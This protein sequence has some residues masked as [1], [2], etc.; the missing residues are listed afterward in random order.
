MQVGSLLP[1][2][3]NARKNRS[4]LRPALT[5]RRKLQKHV[6]VLRNTGI[7]MPAEIGA[8]APR[9]EVEQRAAVLRASGE[10]STSSAMVSASVSINSG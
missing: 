10:A 8:L 1:G 4:G 7:N 6:R 2:G 3:Q 5:F 9:R